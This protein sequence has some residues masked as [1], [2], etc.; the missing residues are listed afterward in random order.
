MN[1]FG[2]GFSTSFDRVQPKG[3]VEENLNQEILISFFPLRALLPWV[4]SARLGFAIDAL[5]SSHI[6]RGVEQEVKEK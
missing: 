2:R 1:H 5:F 3:G 6:K 4:F